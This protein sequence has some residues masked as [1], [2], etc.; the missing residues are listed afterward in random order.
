MHVKTIGATALMMLATSCGQEKQPAEKPADAGVSYVQRLQAMP[1]GQRNGVLIRAIRDAGLDCQRVARS[2]A[3]NVQGRPA[4]TATCDD[5][6]SWT[7]VIA[8][9]GI[10]QI[11]NPKEVAPVK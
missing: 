3:A 2:E 9:N 6:T 11:L 5:G 1:E 4:W 8:D 10:A 7:I